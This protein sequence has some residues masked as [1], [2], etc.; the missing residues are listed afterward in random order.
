ML[1]LHREML[2]TLGE[3]VSLTSRELHAGRASILLFLWPVCGLTF[4][5]D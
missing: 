5:K 1:E 4:S 2:G 3:G